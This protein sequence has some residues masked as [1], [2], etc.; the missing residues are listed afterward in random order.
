MRVQHIEQAL[1]G[2]YAAEH[3]AG[4]EIVERRIERLQ[5]LIWNGYHEEA[6]RELCGMRHTASEV[7]YLN[8]E[9]FRSPIAGTCG[10]EMIHG[11]I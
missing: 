4:L 10:T 5:H 6:R 8:G 9:R 11:A 3:R 1:R 7:V 2:V